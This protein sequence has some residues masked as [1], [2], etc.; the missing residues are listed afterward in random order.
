MQI[1]QRFALFSIYKRRKR[2]ETLPLVADYVPGRKHQKNIIM[3]RCFTELTDTQVAEFREVFNIF[4]ADNNGSICP[5]ELGIVM[6]ALGQNP[7]EAE[8]KE[9][10][11]E[12][13]N[14]GNGVIEFEEFL[15]LMTVMMNK[16]DE[17][18]KEENILQA[19]EVFDRDRDGYISVPELKEF[20]HSIGEMTLNDE[21]VKEMIRAADKNNDGKLDYLEFKDMMFATKEPD[22]P[23]NKDKVEGS[24]KAILSQAAQV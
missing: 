16:V 18:K 15:G 22:E 20:F 8:L 9:M 14:N 21:D 7:S 10:M 2:I 17:D 6:R 12:A 5:T 1:L 19:F 23:C 11:E 4:D 3:S 24:V 13:D